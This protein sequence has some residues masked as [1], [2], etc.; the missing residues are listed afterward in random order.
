MRDFWVFVAFLVTVA[1]GIAR[2]ASIEHAPP[3][4]LTAFNVFKDFAHIW[5]GALMGGAAWTASKTERTSL[6]FM[7]GTVTIVETIAAIVT[8]TK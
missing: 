5:V 8:L 3:I 2:V 7:A 6:A 1:F 4:E